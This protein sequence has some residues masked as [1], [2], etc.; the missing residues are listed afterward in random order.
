MRLGLDEFN[1]FKR[2][3]RNMSF[4]EIKAFNDKVIE[5]YPDQSC[6]YLPAV[7]KFF[8]TIEPE[9]V[10]EL[11][12]ADGELAS[13]MLPL[14]PDIEVWHNYELTEFPDNVC[15]DERYQ[16]FVPP[17]FAWEG[18]EQ[19]E[20]D[21]LVGCHVFEH[22]TKAQMVALLDHLPGVR[23]IFT[24]Y[25]TDDPKGWSNSTDTHVSELSHEGFVEL[26][27]EHGFQL[28]FEEGNDYKHRS[29]AMGFERC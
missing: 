23:W 26:L 24:D 10:F 14:Q 25:P 20:Y 17:H 27:K 7:I 9:R 13:Q 2:N 16:L 15:H 21:T 12:G 18:E 28:V 11:G 5:E 29:V 4:E 8:A 22:I 19:G 1:E 6:F 3:Y